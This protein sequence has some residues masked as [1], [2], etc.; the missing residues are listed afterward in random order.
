MAD[1]IKPILSTNKYTS[2]VNCI[3]HLSKHNVIDKQ[4]MS[5]KTLLLEGTEP[6]R[7][8]ETCSIVKNNANS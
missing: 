7:Y 8:L 1:S 4:L 5:I 6:V 2:S 3:S